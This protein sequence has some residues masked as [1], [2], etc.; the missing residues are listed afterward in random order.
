[1]SKDYDMASKEAT[2]LAKYLKEELTSTILL[3]PSVCNVF[4]VNNVYR[5]G[6]IL[7]YKKEENLYPALEKVLDHYKSNSKVTIDV[8]FSPN[9]I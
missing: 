3:G 9:H 4:R 7:K 5:F 8:D 6:I 1:M 2:K